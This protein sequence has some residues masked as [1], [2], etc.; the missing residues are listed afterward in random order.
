MGMLSMDRAPSYTRMEWLVR[1]MFDSKIRS[2]TCQMIC[3]TLWTWMEVL[4][5]R[6]IKGRH[7][8]DCRRRR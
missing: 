8:V 6:W 7:W 1:A 5:D 4:V 3:T 2:A